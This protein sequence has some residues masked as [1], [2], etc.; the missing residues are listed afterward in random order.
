MKK[1]TLYEYIQEKKIIFVLTCTKQS[2][3]QD[4]S[5][6]NKEDDGGSRTLTNVYE[7]RLHEIQV[8]IHTY[9]T[10]DKAEY[11]E[12]INKLQQEENEI[13]KQIGD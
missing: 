6:K 10:Q 4:K 13:L 12:E 8:L 1:K 9:K 5:N 11:T 7:N 3:T 2:Y